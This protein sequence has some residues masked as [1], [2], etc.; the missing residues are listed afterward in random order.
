MATILKRQNKDSVSYRIQ[1]RVRNKGTGNAETKVLTWRKP[2][3]MTEREAQREAQ[4]LSVEF[5]EKVRIESENVTNIKSS[6]KL[7]DYCGVW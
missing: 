2:N 6:M 4:R 3:E 1:V 7:K 5:E